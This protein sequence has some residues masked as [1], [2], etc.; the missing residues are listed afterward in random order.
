MKSILCR[1]HFMFTFIRPLPENERQVAVEQGYRD[2]KKLNKILSQHY[3]LTPLLNLSEI[4]MV[5]IPGLYAGCIPEIAN[6]L[7]NDLIEEEHLLDKPESLEL[8][9]LERI[10]AY[11]NISIKETKELLNTL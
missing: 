8:Y 9:S 1:L 5:T 7:N 10:M 2:F 3:K 11:I 4:G 6:Q